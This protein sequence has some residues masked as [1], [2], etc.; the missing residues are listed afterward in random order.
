MPASYEL[1]PEQL[2]TGTDPA[3]LPFA[4]TEDL[5]SLDVVIGQARAISAIELA[6]EVCRPGFN[7][8]AL[9]PAG[10]G[11]QST[12][13][14]Y[15]TRRAE[16]QPTPDDWCYVNNFENPQKP[17]ALRLPAGMGH[18]LCLDMQKLVDDT[19]T[20]MP[21]AFEAENYQKQLQ[22]I[23]EY[24]EQRRS[25]PFNELSEQAAAS[26]IALIR[27][28]QGFVLAPIV[29][30]K[31]IDHKEFTKLPE[32]DQQRIN[33]LIGEY[34]DRLNSLLKNS[35]MSARQGKIWRKSAVYMA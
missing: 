17:N 9:G 15:L 22:G 6:I 26:N 18:S 14:Q 32:L 11:K 1:T 29:N 24:Y 10:I 19:R 13:L 20:S 8:F 30:G 5:E 28:P 27:G 25:Q 21:V 16:S 4:T 2:F 33:T 12:I 7:L 35:Q 23:Q 34:E 31:A 3:T